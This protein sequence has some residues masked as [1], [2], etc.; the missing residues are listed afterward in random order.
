[1]FFTAAAQRQERVCIIKHGI[2]ACSAL[3]AYNVEGLASFI[4][5]VNFRV[6]IEVTQGVFNLFGGLLDNFVLKSCALCFFCAFT[7]MLPLFKLKTINRSSSQITWSVN[8]NSQCGGGENLLFTKE[9]SP[10]N[11]FSFK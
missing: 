8:S 2:D 6:S 3:R 5:D 11:K 7:R 10:K 1:M 4:W 9:N